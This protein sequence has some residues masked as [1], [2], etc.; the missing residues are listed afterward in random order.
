M[1]WNT[2][3][4]ISRRWSTSSS[5]S[6]FRFYITF[7]PISNDCPTLYTLLFTFFSVRVLSWLRYCSSCWAFCC[8]S[9]N[10]RRIFAEASTASR[11]PG[12]FSVKSS[13]SWSPWRRNQAWEQTTRQ[14]WIRMKNEREVLDQ[15]TK[16]QNRLRAIRDSTSY[17]NYKFRNTRRN[18]P[19]EEITCGFLFQ[20]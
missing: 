2:R 15:E 7:V 4:T 5:L 3:S 18:N 11:V 1:C 16:Q 20:H 19:P 17:R 14:H 9:F 13:L 10:S 12:C 6:A 8:T